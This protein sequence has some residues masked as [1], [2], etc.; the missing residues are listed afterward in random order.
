[1]GGRGAVTFLAMCQ[2]KILWGTL[3]YGSQ[4]ENPKMC[5]ILKTA[6]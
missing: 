2:A 1:M 6:V 4:Y 5:N 3:K